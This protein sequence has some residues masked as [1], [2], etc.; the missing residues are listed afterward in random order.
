M[1]KTFLQ[2]ADKLKP[3]SGHASLYIVNA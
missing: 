1:V 3:S 2:A